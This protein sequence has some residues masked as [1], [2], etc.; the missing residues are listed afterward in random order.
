[1][2]EKPQATAKP[3]MVQIAVRVEEPLVERFD[4]VARQAS[5][6]SIASAT[7]SSVARAAMLAGIGAVERAIACA[8]SL[9]PVE[10]ETAVESTSAPEPVATTTTTEVA[11]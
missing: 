1:M 5:L 7:R 8:G 4:R 2:T 9:E 3:R 11:S 10:G 6:A